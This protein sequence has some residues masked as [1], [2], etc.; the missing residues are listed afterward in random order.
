M[1]YRYKTDPSTIF[2]IPNRELQGH[3]QKLFKPRARTEIA[4][5]FFTHRVIDNWN[6]LPQDTIAAPTVKTFQNRLRALP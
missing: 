2:S 4:K 3:S 6:A 5:N 1:N